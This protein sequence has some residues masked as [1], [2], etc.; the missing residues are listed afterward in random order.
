LP[1]GG[2]IIGLLSPSAAS[3]IRAGADPL[4][5]GDERSVVEDGAETASVAD[6]YAL[7]A[8]AVVRIAEGS[9]LDQLA[10]ILERGLCYGAGRQRR[11]RGVPAYHD[12]HDGA[13]SSG[14]VGGRPAAEWVQGGLTV[15]ELNEEHF[16]I[17][18]RHM[19]EVIA[20]H[21]ELACEELG[22]VALDERVIAALRRVPRHHFVPGPFAPYAYHDRPLPI[23]FDKTI[24]QPF[25][26]AIMT[27]LL[28]PRL[29]EVVL[30]VG[31]G[32]GYQ[33]A[34]LAELVRQVWSVEVVEEFAAAA[35]ARLRRLGYAHVG[36]RVGDGSRGWAEHAPFDKI[37]VTAAAELIPPALIEQ[38]KS[39]GR[40]VL[41]IGPPEMQ[42]LTVV[43]KDAAGRVKLRQLIPVRF[44]LLETVQ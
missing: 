41:P 6:I 17:L 32:L 15:K 29:H 7:H 36:I 33:V 12:R 2:R 22:K 37:I 11:S 27:D 16:A 28:D 31:T 13:P 42:K 9:P 3:S 38:L 23:G 40:M 20:I 39:G 24:S 30:E 21:V 25:L 44:S 8:K 1:S 14:T 5:G 35:E 10:Q 4:V 26:V 34:V 18:R 19:V 43:D